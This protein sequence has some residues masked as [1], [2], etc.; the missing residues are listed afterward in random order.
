MLLDSN[1]SCYLF[2]FIMFATLE[3]SLGGL[4]GAYVSRNFCI[5]SLWKA[6]FCSTLLLSH[7]R[8]CLRDR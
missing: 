4:G 8:A 2:S 1:V 5:V 3:L 7:I 6:L